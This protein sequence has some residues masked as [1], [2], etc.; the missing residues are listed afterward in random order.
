MH[1]HVCARVNTHRHTNKR[2]KEGREGSCRTGME[3]AKE[4][5]LRKVKGTKERV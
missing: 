2:E 5:S 4:K 3:R 1:M